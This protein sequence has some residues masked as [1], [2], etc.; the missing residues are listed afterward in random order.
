MPAVAGPPS[1]RL[2]PLFFSRLRRLDCTWSLPPRDPLAPGRP[3]R[4]AAHPESRNGAC[5]RGSVPGPGPASGAPCIVSALRAVAARGGVRGDG[6]ARAVRLGTPGPPGCP[7]RPCSP[8]SGGAGSAPGHRPPGGVQPAACPWLP[9]ILRVCPWL[10]AS[11]TRAVSR[12][13]CLWG[14]LPP[15]RRPRCYRPVLPRCLH[16][17]PSP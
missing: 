14:P 17:S 15:R 7:E 3:P 4:G 6:G 11:H 1:W 13:L 16:L 2:R 8:R 5:T 10:S 12:N 9:P